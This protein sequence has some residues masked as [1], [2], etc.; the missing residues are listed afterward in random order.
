MSE[1]T[2]QADYDFK[3]KTN[4]RY[5]GAG[6]DTAMVMPCPAC[7]EPGW[8]TQKITE[9]QT[10]MQEESICKYCGRGFK[11]LMIVDEPNQMQFE[12]VQTVGPDITAP[13][14]PKMRRFS[15]ASG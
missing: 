11:A 12:I 9:T 6:V 8:K 15:D 13:W 5:E 10:R 2:S 3:Y 1:P 4:C 14:L 7:A